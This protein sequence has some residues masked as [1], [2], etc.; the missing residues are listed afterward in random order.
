MGVMTGIADQSVYAAET[1]NNAKA[2][3]TKEYKASKKIKG[4]KAN[5]KKVTILNLQAGWN[6]DVRTG[7]VVTLDQIIPFKTDKKVRS[8]L[9]QCI[10]DQVGEK[11]GN[12]LY[13][14]PNWDDFFGNSPEYEVNFTLA[15]GKVTLIFNQY[16]IAPYVAGTIYIELD[17]TMENCFTEYGKELLG[18]L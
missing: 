3:V 7:D 11:G 4:T 12:L 6:F 18:N 5:G 2:V 15:D 13:D 17:E 9:V 1:E 14:N 8:Q 10:E 16:D